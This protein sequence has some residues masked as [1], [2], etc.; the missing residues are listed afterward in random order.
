MDSGT[1]RLHIKNVV[2][3]LGKINHTK[4]AR[5]SLVAQMVKNLPAM[6]ETRVQSPGREDPLENF[7]DW[8]ATACEVA[9]SNTVHPTHTF[10][11][12]K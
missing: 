4:T 7:M 5:A 10:T 9:E 3:I 1:V 12:L 11:Y 2:F 8:Q 6:R